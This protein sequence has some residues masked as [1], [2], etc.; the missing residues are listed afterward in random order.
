MSKNDAIVSVVLILGITIFLTSLAISLNFSKVYV[1]VTVN[2][3]ECVQIVWGYL[4][5]EE[6]LYCRYQEGR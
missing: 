3:R 4:P 1:P 6:G 2:G 5:D